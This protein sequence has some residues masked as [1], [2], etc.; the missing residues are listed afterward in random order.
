MNIGGGPGQILVETT[1]AGPATIETR[2]REVLERNIWYFLA[3]TR[4]GT[5]VRTYINGVDE[6]ET[7]GTHNTILTCVNEDFTIGRYSSWGPDYTDGQMWFPRIWSRKL[8]PSE[9]KFLYNS[10]RILLGV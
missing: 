10:E 8:D 7:I 1:E 3:F 2:S 6:T 4:S 5:S 9:I